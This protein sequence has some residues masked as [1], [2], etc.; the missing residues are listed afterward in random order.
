MSS[1]AARRA[2]KRLCELA[3]KWSRN[4]LPEPAHEHDGIITA[5]ECEAQ[6]VDLAAQIIDEEMAH[7]A[8]YGDT[9]RVLDFEY[10]KETGLPCK[11]RAE[12]IKGNLATVGQGKPPSGG[13][14]G[15][16]GEGE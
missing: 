1:A 12:R 11:V 10:D 2:G 13:G 6:F 15:K 8:H 5:D 16:E 4:E 14:E 7:D 3:H 9:I